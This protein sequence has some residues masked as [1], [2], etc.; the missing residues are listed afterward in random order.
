MLSF[1]YESSS[2]AVLG[3]DGPSTFIGEAHEMRS[4]EWSYTLGSRSLRSATRA[5]REVAIH[6]QFTDP[7]EADLLCEVGDFDVATGAYGKLRC[8]GWE[9]RA[10]IVSQTPTIIRR[11]FLE[12]DLKIALLDGVWRLPRRF[13]FVPGSDGGGAW[14]DLP[15]DA[16]YDLAEPPAPTHIEVDGIMPMPAVIIVYGPA[17]S[18]YVRIAGN[19]YEAKCNVPANGYL[20]I[21]PI[22]EPRKAY[23]VDSQGNVTDVMSALVRGSGAG[24]GTYA[25]ER[26]PPGFHEVSWPRTFGFDVVVYRERGDVPWTQ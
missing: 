19:T 10:A 3:L 2:G 21:D 7:S 6:A 24:C 9:Q 20:V 12:A 4:R 8:N 11:N 23:V 5:A 13:S 25:F 1:E 26:V 16:P 18:P 22:S 15:N 17:N 14:L